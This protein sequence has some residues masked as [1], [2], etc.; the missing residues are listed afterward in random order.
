VCIAIAGG[1]S[2]SRLLKELAK[3]PPSVVS[4]QAFLLLTAFY[5]EALSVG[6]IPTVVCD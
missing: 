1:V 2:R 3:E 5:A 6:L 4:I